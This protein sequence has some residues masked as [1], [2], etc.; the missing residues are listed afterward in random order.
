MVVYGV[1]FS[2]AVG[3]NAQEDTWVFFHYGQNKSGYR[4]AESLVEG[5]PLAPVAR[6]SAGS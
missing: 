3:N 4:N 5:G 6:V 1:T 2:L